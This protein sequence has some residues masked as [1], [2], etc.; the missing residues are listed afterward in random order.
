MLWS[1]PI[2]ILNQGI[3]TYLYES[4]VRIMRETS[5]SSSEKLEMAKLMGIDV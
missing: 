1:I 2:A 3:H 5:A 4:G